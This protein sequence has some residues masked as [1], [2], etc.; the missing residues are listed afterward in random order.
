VLAYGAS[1]EAA[2]RS[3]EAL[4]LRVLADKLEAG[5]EKPSDPLLRTGWT[6]S[7]SSSGSHT[8]LTHPTKGEYVGVP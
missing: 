5:A 6:V 3:V 8:Q 4:A 2:I 7:R 1:R